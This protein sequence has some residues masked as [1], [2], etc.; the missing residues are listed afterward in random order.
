MKNI[1]IN[2][3]EKLN[4]NIKALNEQLTIFPKPEDLVALSKIIKKNIPFYRRRDFYAYMTYMN[5]ANMNL[6]N[7]PYSF[8]ANQNKADGKNKAT[9]PNQ[10]EA[11]VKNVFPTETVMW[12]NYSIRGSQAASEFKA[13]VAEKAKISEED[14]LKISPSKYYSFVNFKTKEALEASLSALEGVNYKG[15]VLKVNRK[16]N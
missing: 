13:Y 2:D 6:A 1:D 5:L 12:M 7:M 8:K 15:K 4:E 11:K 16:T 10:G 14:I 9:M 3:I